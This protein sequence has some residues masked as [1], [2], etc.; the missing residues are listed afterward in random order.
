VNERK[1]TTQRGVSDSSTVS[2]RVSSEIN[3]TRDVSLSPDDD[4]VDQPAMTR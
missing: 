2:A 4:V 3:L 1:T